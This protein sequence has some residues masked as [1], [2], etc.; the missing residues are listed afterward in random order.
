MNGASNE[1]QIELVVRDVEILDAPERRGKEAVARG[2]LHFKA[3]FMIVKLLGL[4]SDSRNN[5]DG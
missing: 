3:L 4:I 5:N 1:S 2:T